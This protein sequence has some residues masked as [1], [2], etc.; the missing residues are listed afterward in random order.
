MRREIAQRQAVGAG[1]ADLRHVPARRI[2]PLQRALRSRHGR[3]RHGEGLAERSDLE[4]RIGLNGCLCRRIGRTEIEQLPAFRADDSDRDARRSAGAHEVARSCID[5]SSK[6][7]RLRKSAR[8]RKRNDGQ[9]HTEAA[10]TENAMHGKAFGSDAMS[11]GGHDASQVRNTSSGLRMSA[12]KVLEMLDD[13]PPRKGALLTSANTLAWK[14]R[15]R[16]A[17][18]EGIVSPDHIRIPGPKDQVVRNLESAPGRFAHEVPSSA[19]EWRTRHE[20]SDIP[21]TY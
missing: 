12:I 11:I 6:G 21:V 17:V 20:A 4:Q 9:A 5:Q 19:R 15:V 16:H 7:V 18:E 14:Q 2:L 1:T 13:Q 10:A 3:E 8:C